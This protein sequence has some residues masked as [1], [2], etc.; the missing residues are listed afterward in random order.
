M[1]DFFTEHGYKF[2]LA[3]GLLVAEKP[4]VK[5]VC[6]DRGS[7]LTVLEC[8]KQQR[9]SPSLSKWCLWS[10]MVSFIFTIILW[11]PF[12]WVYSVFTYNFFF[13]CNA[14]FSS[15]NYFDLN[16]VKMISLIEIISFHLIFFT[17]LICAFSFLFF[18]P[19]FLEYL[20]WTS[21]E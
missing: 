8:V 7:I 19:S 15:L 21:S 16:S 3:L 20:F 2:I 6:A 10:L 18:T 9:L 13:Y 11:I 12:F 4:E 14:I 1:I 17:T 5:S